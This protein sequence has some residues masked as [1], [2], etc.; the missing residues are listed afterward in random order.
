MSLIEVNCMKLPVMSSCKLVKQHAGSI[1]GENI[2]DQLSN[3]EHLKRN[4]VPWSYNSTSSSE[5]WHVLSP[6]WAMK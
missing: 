4:C 2:L 1:N 3:Y 5:Y 6:I